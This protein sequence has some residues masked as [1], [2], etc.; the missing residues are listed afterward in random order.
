MTR[1]FL[2]VATVVALLAAPC[3]AAASG[4]AAKR[5]GTVRAFGETFKLTVDGPSCK[6]ARST[7]TKYGRVSRAKGCGSHMGSGP[8]RVNGYDCATSGSD[9]FTCSKGKRSIIARLVR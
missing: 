2:L 6:L 3:V 9:S 4:S 7:A 1:T 5:C 8:C